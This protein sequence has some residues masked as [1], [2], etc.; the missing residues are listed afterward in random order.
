MGVYAI[1]RNFKLA[2][3]YYADCLLGPDG[4]PSKEA[5]VINTCTNGTTLVKVLMITVFVVAILLETC[6]CLSLIWRFML[7]TEVFFFAAACFIVVS[8]SKQLVE[9]EREIM[10]KDTESW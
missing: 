8:Y 10:I 7:L 6:M 5:S 2:P 3:K 1:H 4:V 9:E